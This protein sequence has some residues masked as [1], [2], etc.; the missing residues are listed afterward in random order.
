MEY[1]EQLV[2]EWYEYQGYFV[3]RDL[4]VGLESD[5]SYECELN[6]VCYHPQRNHLVHI[7]PSMDLLDW[8]E[9][10]VH[11]KTKFDAARKYLHRMFVVEPEPSVEYVAFL[12]FPGE[13]SRKFVAG[14]RVLL[15]SELLAEILT[16]L[17]R[18][19]I[20]SYM[21]PE[22]WPLLRTLQFVAEFR[23]PV[24][25]SLVAKGRHVSTERS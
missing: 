10:E 24:C 1:I 21:I 14:A 12:A 11:F 13:K 6:V 16:K 9:R 19:N 4:W 25:E 7:E 8:N 23:G 3:H 15:M 20:A 17:K 18:F 2:L 5:G 22:Q